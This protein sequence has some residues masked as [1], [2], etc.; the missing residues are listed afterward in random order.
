M[1]QDHLQETYQ[2]LFDQA[3]LALQQGGSMRPFGAGTRRTGETI[4][5]R[6]ETRPGDDGAAPHIQGLI[7]G[8]RQ[9][10]AEHGLIAAGLVFD[11]AVEDG[12]TV[13]SRALCF[14]LEAAN[15]RAL[16]VI[17]PYDM[18]VGAVIEFAEPAIEEV[19]PEVFT[20][21]AAT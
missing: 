3:H 6:V 20:A 14:H 9:E 15:G 12:G 16:Q 8:F 18:R 11:A 5:A 7:A 4:E 13:F 17:V 21:A 10:D 19:L 2:Y 1:L